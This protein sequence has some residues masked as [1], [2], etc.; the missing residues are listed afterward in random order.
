MGAA[1]VSR[2]AYRDDPI[3]RF[4]LR[5]ILLGMIW[6]FLGGILDLALSAAGLGSFASVAFELLVSLWRGVTLQ[7]PEA[8]FWLAGAP[9]LLALLI[10][11]LMDLGL[12]PA[13]RPAPSRRALADQVEALL[14]RVAKAEAATAR[15][16]RGVFERVEVKA[17]RV[18]DET[19][20]MRAILGCEAE[21]A[22]LGLTDERGTL[23][24]AL[25]VGADGTPR[26]A[27]YDADERGRIELA[28]E[29]GEPLVAVR[30]SAAAPDA[31]KEPGPPGYL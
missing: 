29:G 16:A 18:C 7:A 17:F 3:T 28:V 25:H 27:L 10:A 12:V 2:E 4:M 21:G 26:V 13:F 6:L 15:V 31:A 22:M 23:R 9:W 14:E 5:W 20:R 11:L 19:G 30:R 8:F 24:L 1:E